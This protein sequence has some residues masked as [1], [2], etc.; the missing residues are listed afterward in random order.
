MTPPLLLHVLVAASISTASVS[1][2]PRKA[3]VDAWKGRHVVVTRTLYTMVYRLHGFFG[4]TYR[5]KRDGLTVVTPD[6]VFFRFDAREGDID[7]VGRTP[8]EVMDRM[9]GMYFRD[10]VL[11]VGS[12]Q[13]RQASYID[14]YEP[15]A[16]LVVKSVKITGE[17]I[18]F[19]LAKP[20]SDDSN[21]RQLATTLTVQWPTDLS[22]S[23]RER[24]EIARL[25]AQFIAARPR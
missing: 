16:E 18:R 22:Q 5:G 10:E 19:V 14:R 1:A 3:F 9:K 23:L 7:A 12:V 24:P 15:G 11:D 17:R 20:S 25:I 4:E 6:D 21:E 13:S 8:E 2:N